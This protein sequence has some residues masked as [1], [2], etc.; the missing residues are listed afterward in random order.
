MA[1]ESLRPQIAHAP[2]G[3]LAD[4]RYKTGPDGRYAIPTRDKPFGIVVVHEKGFGDLTAE[5][6]ARSADVT[7]RP[8]GRIEGT[9]RIRDKPGILEQIDVNVNRSVIAPGYLYQSY[10]AKTDTQGRFA[11]ERVMD[12]EAS[13]TWS[14][15][16]LVTRARSSAGSNVN[17]RAGETL[18][19]DLG[20]EGR[21][22][23][24]RIVLSAAEGA[25]GGD[26]VAPINPGNALGWIELKPTEMPVPPDFNT[27]DAKKRQSHK[28]RW[29]RTEPG[30]AY[31]RSRR[32]HSF[33]VGPDGQ[34]RIEDITPGS[35]SLH[36]SAGSTPGLSHPM[37]HNRLE[38]EVERDFEV[39]TI[40]GGHTDLPL[41][42]GTMPLKLEVKN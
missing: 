9:F 8:W 28:L 17:L 6:L 32:F 5:Q 10:S 13:F 38:G 29:Y 39:P 2:P 19:V 11:I 20:G 21:P 35:Y 40:P 31:M 24:G 1:G 16:P 18:R 4:H 23:I 42:L 37:T 12:G 25:R 41:D 3:F 7:L 33:P 26:A 15:G 36:I 34:F 22:L 30:K 14:R 27:W